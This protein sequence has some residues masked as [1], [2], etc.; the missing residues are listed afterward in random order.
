V[1]YAHAVP[2]SR[3]LSTDRMHLRPIVAED[4]DPLVELDADPEVMRFINDGKPNPR[5]LY[6]RELMGRMMAYTDRPFGFYAA[7]DRRGPDDRDAAPDPLGEF[8]GWFHLRPSVADESILELGYRLRRS[9]WGIGLATEGSM[10]LL[11]RAFEQLD[12]TA[13]DACADPR[14]EPSLQVMRKCGMKRV[15]MFRHPRAPI[16][17][18][19]YL[20]T[21]EEFASRAPAAIVRRP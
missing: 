4:I 12:Q 5:E 17:V 8:L 18:V 21:R 1:G 14:N 9:A 16:D 7:L 20:I 11:R 6:E 13:V 3:E 10:A 15:G 19:R 2:V